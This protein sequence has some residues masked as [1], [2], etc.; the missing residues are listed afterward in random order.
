MHATA[1]LN[2]Q[3][4]VLKCER[5]RTLKTALVCSHRHETSSVGTSTETERGLTVIRGWREGS[6]GR[7]CRWVSGSSLG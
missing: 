2:I 3:N 7:D 5:S 4:I 1:W 6:M